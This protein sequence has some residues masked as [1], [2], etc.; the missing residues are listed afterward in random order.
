M[1]LVLWI[2]WGLLFLSV[3]IA[4][5]KANNV[6]SSDEDNVSKKFIKLLVSLL[7]HLI[8]SFVTFFL[9]ILFIFGPEPR[10]YNEMDLVSKISCA[11]LVLFYGVGGWL[12]ASFIYGKFITSLKPF[13]ADA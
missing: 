9:F 2:I 1:L 12:L 8:I 7:A 6:F 10:P 13:I 5:F 4:L 3:P 11:I